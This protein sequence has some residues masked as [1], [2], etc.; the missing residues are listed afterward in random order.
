MLQGEARPRP[1]RGKAQAHGG[2]HPLSP[3]ADKHFEP[4]PKPIGGPPYHYNL[5]TAMPGITKAA[6]KAGRLVFHTV[7]D[8]GGIKNSDYQT[9]VA[10]E[11]KGDLN[12]PNGE[13]PRFFYHLGDVVYYNG[14]VGE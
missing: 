5:E 9:A 3:F 14:A 8:T 1:P 10:A 12:R 4:L 11:M 7:G 13:R 6:A 2:I